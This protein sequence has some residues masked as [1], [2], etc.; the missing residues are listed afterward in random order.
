MKFKLHYSIT[1][2]VIDGFMAKVGYEGS[3][4]KPYTAHSQVVP[5][6]DEAHSLIDGLIAKVYW[7]DCER[8]NGTATATAT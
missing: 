6:E 8:P 3:D 2:P 5:T 1:V 7:E 4:G